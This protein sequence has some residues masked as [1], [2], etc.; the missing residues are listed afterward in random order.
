[1]EGSY[2]NRTTSVAFLISF[3]FFPIEEG[4]KEEEPEWETAWKS[5]RG[6]KKEK[7]KENYMQSQETNG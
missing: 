7:K 6:R 5:Q 1:M 2:Y 4:S 3:F